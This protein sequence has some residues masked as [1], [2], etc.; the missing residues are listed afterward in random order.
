M[1]PPPDPAAELARLRR[2]ATIWTW[3]AVAGV[4]LTVWGW[5]GAPLCRAPVAATAPRPV[6]LSTPV[7]RPSYIKMVS[8]APEGFGFI[9]SFILAGPDGSP[10]QSP[11]T[12]ILALYDEF[13][14]D[15]SLDHKL[16]LQDTFPI[17]LGNYAL[18]T[19]GYLGCFLPR[20]D[21]SREGTIRQTTTGAFYLLRFIADG[22]TLMTKARAPWPL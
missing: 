3:V 10:V 9:F 2:K 15:G 5:F 13:Y 1:N 22:E 21:V 6:V 20:V 18:T 12:V 11:G 17:T 19:S 7:A 16:V 8:A 4:I 14:G